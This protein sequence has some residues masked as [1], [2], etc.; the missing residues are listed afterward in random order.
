[1]SNFYFHSQMPRRCLACQRRRFVDVLPVET[2]P[3]LR[4]VG[5]SASKYKPFTTSLIK[6]GSTMISAWSWCRL[7]QERKHATL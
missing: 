4:S 5:E 7:L 6:I 2:C 3:W 1:M